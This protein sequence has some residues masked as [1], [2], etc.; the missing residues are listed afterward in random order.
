MTSN[1][2]KSVL[3][4][5][6]QIQLL[7][8][9]LESSFLPSDDTDP[10]SSGNRYLRIVGE[11]NALQSCFDAFAR[12]V[13]QLPECSDNVQRCKAQVSVLYGRFCSLQYE[14]S[15]TVDTGISEPGDLTSEEK[16]D[17]PE[18]SDAPEDVDPDAEEAAP[19]EEDEGSDDAE[20]EKEKKRKKKKEQD[21]SELYD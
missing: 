16:E 3:D 10:A 8:D 20:G 2:E 9:R 15:K 5:A 4:C 18:E 6:A 7:Y 13:K 11:I 17:S 1:D 12:L 14:F 19:E 21:L